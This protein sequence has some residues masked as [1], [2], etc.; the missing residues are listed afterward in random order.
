MHKLTQAYEMH[1]CY[2]PWLLHKALPLIKKLLA[3][4]WCVYVGK[5]LR[6]PSRLDFSLVFTIFPTQQ[7]QQL[8]LKKIFFPV[9]QTV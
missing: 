2:L 3:V 6:A 1:L 4:C 5:N 8:L 9:D 7:R